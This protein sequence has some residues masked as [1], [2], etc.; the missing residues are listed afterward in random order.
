MRASNAVNRAGS[1]GACGFEFTT[2][3]IRASITFAESLIGLRGRPGVDLS[4]APA[5]TH[6]SAGDSVRGAD[7]HGN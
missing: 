5:S 4:R 6:S 2:F 1:S 7:Y 3:A